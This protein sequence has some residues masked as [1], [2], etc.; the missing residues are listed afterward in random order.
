MLTSQCEWSSQTCQYAAEGGHLNVLKW[1]R[2]NDCPWDSNTANEA[3]LYYRK[4][5][6]ILVLQWVLENGCPW[7]IEEQF[8][9]NYID[10]LKPEYQKELLRVA[11]NNGIKLS[12][13]PPT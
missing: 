9:K 13:I 3:Y 7:E 8:K 4:T 5:I 1:A 2:R 10:T 12:S 11:N 6:D